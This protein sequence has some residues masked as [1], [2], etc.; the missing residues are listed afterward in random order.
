MVSRH[1][2]VDGRDDPRIK[3]GDGHDGEAV[4]WEFALAAPRLLEMVTNIRV[5]PAGLFTRSPACSVA[6]ISASASHKIVSPCSRFGL[7]MGLCAA[8]STL[9]AKRRMPGLRVPPCRTA[10]KSSLGPLG[11]LPLFERRE[12]PQRR[13]IGHLVSLNGTQGVIHCRLERGEEDWSVGHL[14]TVAS[15]TSR[16]VGVVCEIAT[17]DGQ[18][19]ETGVNTARVAIELNGEVVDDPNGAPIFHRGVR[20]FPSLGAVTHRIPAP[21]IFAPSTVFTGERPSRSAS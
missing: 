16:M 6:R 9:L 21:T 5:L 19:S 13:I 20:S 2:R 11:E 17:S 8:L 10:G 14:I 15:R 12:T 7:T 1:V 4:A 3:S 18:W